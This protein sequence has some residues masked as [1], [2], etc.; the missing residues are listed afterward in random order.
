[1]MNTHTVVSIIADTSAAIVMVSPA[2]A[3]A[4]TIV[5][6]ETVAGCA[7]TMSTS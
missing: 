4:L 7:E 3:G 1:M 5:S 2:S 6:P